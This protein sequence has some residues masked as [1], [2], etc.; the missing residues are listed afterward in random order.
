MIGE[1]KMTFLK[2]SGFWK[3][4]DKSD[5][6]VVERAEKEKEMVFKIYL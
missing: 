6:G 1:S 2:N 4:E 5:Y 3:E